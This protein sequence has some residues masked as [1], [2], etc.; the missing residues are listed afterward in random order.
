VREQPAQP[1][2]VDE[3]H[4]AALGLG[5]QDLL[6]LLLGADEQDRAVALG[7]ALEEVESLLALD[8]G[9]LQVDDEDP[10][11]FREDVAPHLRV[12]ALRLVAEVD[13]G[14]EELLHSQVRHQF[15]PWRDVEVGIERGRAPQAVVRPRTWCPPWSC[16]GSR[17]TDI[18]LPP[19][20]PSECTPSRFISSLPGLPLAAYCSVLSASL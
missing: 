14:L 6:R 9:L 1:A 7:D 13:A 16:S 18:P 17:S 19:G 11:A 12:G 20:K 15:P 4:A 5:R 3:R 2:L 8:Q 10:V